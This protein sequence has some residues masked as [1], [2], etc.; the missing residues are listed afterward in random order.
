[1]C[2]EHAFAALKGQFQSL[3]ELHL[4]MQTEEDLYIA[5]YWVESLIQFEEGYRGEVE[6]TVQ[7][8]ILEGQG[9]VNRDEEIYQG[10]PAGTEGQQFCAH[11]MQRL[12][13]ECGLRF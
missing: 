5:V 3:C 10:Q 9:S 12:F 1:V 4:Q 6:G 7:W 11:L 8:A 2:I 13:D